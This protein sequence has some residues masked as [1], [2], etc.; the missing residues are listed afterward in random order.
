MR[1][2]IWKFSVDAIVKFFVVYSGYIPS[3]SSGTEEN[4]W[5]ISWYNPEQ[6]IFEGFSKLQYLPTDSFC[7]TPTATEFL[8]INSNNNNNNNIKSLECAPT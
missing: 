8:K 6:Q 1:N 5:V 4:F 7:V 3:C 2:K